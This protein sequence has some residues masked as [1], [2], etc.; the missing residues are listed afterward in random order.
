MTGDSNSTFGK[1]LVVD[2]DRLVLATVVHGLSE[3][4]YVVIDADNG[5]DAILLARE[6]RPDL[7]L[8]DIRMEGKSGFDVAAYLRE[9]LQTP[10]MFLSAFAD[11]ETTAKVREL[12]AIAYLVKPL[13]IRQI[14]PAVEAAFEQIRR[15]AAVAAEQ[16]ASSPASGVSSKPPPLGNA[17]VSG[18]VGV[19]VGA[20]APASLGDKV[21]MA[22]GV[23]MH[24]YS[25]RRDDA[26]VR[27]QQ[28]AA[29]E[30]HSLEAY[31][32]A[33]LKA[34]EVLSLPSGR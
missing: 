24:R 1:I 14:V 30:H 21:S 25:M 11:E 17:G 10:F 29:F 20:S 13:D 27:L 22:V 7:A 2:D 23:V 31:A 8:L 26:L 3:A 33:V 4:G 32:E 12:G 9:Y 15:G 28:Q 18:G 6:H 16:L 19:G 5:D 34:V